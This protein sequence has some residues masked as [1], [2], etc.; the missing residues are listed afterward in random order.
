MPLPSSGSESTSDELDDPAEV[1]ADSSCQQNESLT[2]VPA[3][4]V[5]DTLQTADVIPMMTG[6][7]HD[8]P[9]QVNSTN[10]QGDQVQ[11]TDIHPHAEEEALKDTVKN[12]VLH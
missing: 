1:V 9:D 7:P 12:S 11:I 2:A 6:S 10:D 4:K 3:P 5:M 8:T